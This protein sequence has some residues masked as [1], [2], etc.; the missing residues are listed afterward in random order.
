[1]FDAC[2][3]AE[4]RPAETRAER[5]MRRL[6][7]MADIGLSIAEKLERQAELAAIHAEVDAVPDNLPHSRRL[8]DIG[9]SFAQVSR[10]VSLATALEDRIDKGLPALPDDDRPVRER[11]AREKR[12]EVARSVVHAIEADPHVHSRRRIVRLRLDLDRLLDAEIRDLDRFLRRPFEEIEARLRRDLGLDPE[13]DPSPERGRMGPV[14]EQREDGVTD[15]GRGEP[16]SPPPLTLSGRSAS[17]DAG[18]PSIP[19]RERSLPARAGQDQV[20]GLPLRGAPPDSIGG[21]D[22]EQPE[23]ASK[24]ACMASR[25]VPSPIAGEGFRPPP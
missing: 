3:S 12:A 4:D 1:M 18:N 6:A 5:R 9:R 14:A 24:I 10:A 22:L 20:L 25:A 2:A 16:P 11:E 23:P 19:C 7:R 17:Q 21:R 13:E 8:D 15:A